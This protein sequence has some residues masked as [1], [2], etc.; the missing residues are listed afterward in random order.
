MTDQSTDADLIRIFQ[1]TKTIALIG[2]SLKP[3]R[4][5]FRVG[6]FLAD[7]G[8]RVI[9]INPGH[10]GEML[11]GEKIVGSFADIE[12]PQSVDMIDIFR[13]NEAI[14]AIVDDAL[15]RLPNLK[16]IWM[17]LGLHNAEAAQK[18]SLRGM[19]VVQNKCPKI[20]HPRLLGLGLS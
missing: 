20:E 12:D 17:Q 5:S 16:T 18:A 8:Y 3:I 1:T 11:F 10:V 2:A 13:R 6:E 19:T 4:A 14:P 15:T 9:P 7:I